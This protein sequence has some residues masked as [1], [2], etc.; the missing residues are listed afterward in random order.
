MAYEGPPR[1]VIAAGLVDYFLYFEEKQVQSEPSDD[2][3]PVDEGLSVDSGSGSEM[4]VNDV[5]ITIG[6][7]DIDNAQRL[8][9]AF[10]QLFDLK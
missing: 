1:A 2:S 8:V 6:E 9:N 10:C 4:D 3:L 5:D 7:T